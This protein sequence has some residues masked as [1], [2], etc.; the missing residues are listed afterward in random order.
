MEDLETLFCKSNDFN[1]PNINKDFPY[2][3]PEENILF[4]KDVTPPEA[5]N[6]KNSMSHWLE[7]IPQK[8]RVVMF[9]DKDHLD[10][11]KQQPV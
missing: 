5:Q 2:G 1:V 10:E 4:F 6:V 7:P 11:Y 8:S 9:L 3:S